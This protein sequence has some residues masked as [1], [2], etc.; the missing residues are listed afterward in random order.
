MKIKFL[1]TEEVKNKTVQLPKYETEGSAGMDI[2]AFTDNKTIVIEPFDRAMI[3][4]GLYAEI[5]Q[6]HEAQIR[7]RSGMSAKYGVTVLNAPGTIDS[8]FTGEIK[9]ILINL[10]NRPFII[11]DGDRIAQMVISKYEQTEVT[12]AEKLSDTERGAG[13]FGHTGNK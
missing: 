4:T 7:P 5:E 1:E 3:P 8:D 10:S 13:G 6:G 9:V 11:S 2:R 12:T